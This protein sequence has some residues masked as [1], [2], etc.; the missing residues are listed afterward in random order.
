MKKIFFG[1]LFLSFLIMS[2]VFGGV[3]EAASYN[4]NGISFQYP[5]SWQ[6]LD[7]TRGALF[8][9]MSQT[10]V[11]N[12]NA[13]MNVVKS[14]SDPNFKNLSE[15]IFKEQ[16]L[17]MLSSQQNIKSIEFLGVRKDIWH[18]SPTLFTDY[19]LTYDGLSLHY[20]QVFCDNG[21]NLF[22]IT[23][24]CSQSEWSTFKDTV[25]AIINSVSFL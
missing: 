14:V 8:I 24:V 3:V 16:Y 22:V 19:T 7:D 23:F 1:I 10:R 21:E 20:V 9:G 2:G 13:N 25:V 11:D 5:D 12:F 18:G 15:D 17:E 4:G 6:Q